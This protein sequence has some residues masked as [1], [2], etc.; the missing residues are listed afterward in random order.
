[1]GSKVNPTVIGAFVVGAP[2]VFRGVQVGQVAKVE[3]LFDPSA[4]TIRL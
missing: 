1:M 3:A 4:D 2:V